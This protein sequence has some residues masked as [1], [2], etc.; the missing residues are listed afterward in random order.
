MPFPKTYRTNLWWAVI[1]SCVVGLLAGKGTITRVA[2]MAL[3][4]CGG[5]AGFLVAWEHKWLKGIKGK[6]KVTVTI[7]LMMAV[8]VRAMWPPYGMRVTPESVTYD[9]A[10]TSQNYVFTIK[11]N[12]EET[13]YVAE[14]EFKIDSPNLTPTDFQVYVPLSS[15]KPMYERSAFSDICGMF[16][17]D[18]QNK[19]L[20]VVQIF[21][22]APH[23]TREISLTHIK[24]GEATV[25][26]IPSVFKTTPQPRIADPYRQT[27]TYYAPLMKKSSFVGNLFSQ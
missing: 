12:E 14:T 22:L 11:N 5:V 6:L 19:P 27:C 24:A 3:V 10:N 2:I 13:I 18:K 9:P 15:L 4:I 20:I 21:Y 7:L 16:A 17:M 25:R 8:A 1:V 23:E 26:A